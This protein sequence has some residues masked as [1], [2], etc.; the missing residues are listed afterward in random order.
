[1]KTLYG[2]DGSSPH[3]LGDPAPVGT[4][5][6]EMGPERMEWVV[7]ERNGQDYPPRGAHHCASCTCEVE[8]G[9]YTAWWEIRRLGWWGERSGYKKTG[10]LEPPAEFPHHQPMITLLP[11]H[12]LWT[13]AEAVAAGWT[14][15][16]CPW[17]ELA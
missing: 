10:E 13:A 9:D 16:P 7:V 3:K 8:Q 11:P 5:M 14:A 1:M 12:M 6:L 4:L 15:E 2:Q 17:P